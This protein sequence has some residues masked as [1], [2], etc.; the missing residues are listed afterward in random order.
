MLREFAEIEERNVTQRIFVSYSSKDGPAVELL[1][2]QLEARGVACWISTRDI[3][4][5]HNYPRAIIEAIE[6]AWGL[7]L[8]L[9]QNSNDSVHV[10]NEVERAVSK[11]KRVFPCRME[12]IQP[13]KQLELFIGSAQWIDLFDKDHVLRN[14][15]QLAQSLKKLEPDTTMVLKVAATAKDAGQD[16]PLTELETSLFRK[17]EDLRRPAPGQFLPLAY[18]PIRTGCATLTAVVDPQT[19][20]TFLLKESPLAKVPARVVVFEHMNLDGDMIA[21]PVKQWL[22][23]DK[24]CELLPLVKGWS[25]DDVI[26]LN[27]GV[28]GSLLTTWLRKL[29]QIVVQ[30][31]KHDPPLIHRDI[32]PSNLMLRQKDLSLVLVDC[33]TLVP[34]PV[35]QDVQT[36]GTR[37]YFPPEAMDGVTGLGTDVYAIGATLYCLNH[38]KQPPSAME[39]QYMGASLELKSVEDDVRHVFP[40]LI[41]KDMSGR[42]QDASSA[43]R[44]FMNC[45]SVTKNVRNLGELLLPNGDKLPMRGVL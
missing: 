41:H 30:L 33:T 19:K 13:S 36:V 29:L 45:D 20:E 39:T 9:S 17:L 42:Y 22:A 21:A 37:G 5:G 38:C 12:K 10:A 31:Q 24:Y 8:F 35:P 23:D 7:L 3:S 6:D 18:Q 1:C 16:A 34:F 40:Q 15:A 25:L 14:L 32:K 26:R 43:L 28:Y 44:A 27:S 4:P 2:R 11:G